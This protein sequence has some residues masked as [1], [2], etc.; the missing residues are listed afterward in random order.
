[1]TEKR[2]RGRTGHL[3][4]VNNNKNNPATLAKEVVRLTTIVTSDGQRKTTIPSDA[5]TF[6][7]IKIMALQKDVSILIISIVM[8][9]Q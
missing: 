5:S 2:E 8:V 9:L 7:P 3:F 1:M 6:D 4:W